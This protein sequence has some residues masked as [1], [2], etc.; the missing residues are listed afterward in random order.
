[1]IIKILKYLF[2]FMALISF[3]IVIFSVT[4]LRQLS[5]ATNTPLSYFP[6]TFIDAIKHPSL[7]PNFNFVILGIDPR[8]DSL[9]NTEVSDTIILGRLTKNGKINLLSVPRDLW[10]DNLGAK[11]NQIYPLSKNST[12]YIHQQFSYLSGQNISESIFVTTDNLIEL[13]KLIGG[14]DVYLDSSYTDNQYPNPDYV[15]NPNKKTPIYITVT[16][17]QGTNHLDETNI[18]PFVRSRKGQ[19]TNGSGST[20]LG[21]VIRQQLLIDALF[22]KLKSP[23]FLSQPKNL[24]SLYNFW[25]QNIN[26][27]LTDH[28]LVSLL[29]N[30]PDILKNVSI[31]KG[32]IPTGDNPKTDIIYH[33]T[34]FSNPQWVFIPYDKTYTKFQQFVSNFLAN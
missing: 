26:S 19:F 25:H 28:E 20:D 30:N 8:H 6:N 29:I 24:I 14:V 4:I 5:L 34:T 32:I 10:V 31:H 33:P 21:R 23:S 16:Y 27:T 17:N 3:T 18:T 13:T 7:N 1:M 12:E 2:L 22:T 15:A 11:V 9:E